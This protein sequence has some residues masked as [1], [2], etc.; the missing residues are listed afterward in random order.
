MALSKVWKRRAVLNFLNYITIVY[1]HS[2]PQST[3]I[4]KCGVQTVLINNVKIV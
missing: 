4:L 2:M 1:N 3:I